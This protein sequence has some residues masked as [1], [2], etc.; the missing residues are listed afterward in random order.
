MSVRG[1][2]RVDGWAV[3]FPWRFSGDRFTKF[4]QSTAHASA[5]EKRH[6]NNS[7]I[8]NK[9]KDLLLLF[10]VKRTA[11]IGRLAFP[12]NSIEEVG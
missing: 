5:P 1:V 3:A 12:G 8:L 2:S 6:T 10:S 11:P 4:R 9:V 7:V